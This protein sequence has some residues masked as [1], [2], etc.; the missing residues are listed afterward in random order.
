MENTVTLSRLADLIIVGGAFGITFGTLLYLIVDIILDLI[1]SARMKRKIRKESEE[2][3]Q[4][5]QT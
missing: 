5:E 1:D 3:E 4:A 2:N